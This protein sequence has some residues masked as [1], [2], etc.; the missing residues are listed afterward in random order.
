MTLQDVVN[1]AFELLGGVMNGINVLQLYRH[2]RV[3]GV[4]WAPTTLFTLW[5]FWNLYYYPHL[6][7]WMSFVGG[8]GIVASNFAWVCMALYYARRA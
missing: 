6:A 3:M 5:G 7:Q 2:K 4:H 1:G 8:C